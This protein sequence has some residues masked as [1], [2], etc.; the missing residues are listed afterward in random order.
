M[1]S[2]S[3]WAFVGTSWTPGQA[4]RGTR[5][6]RI[7]KRDGVPA[8]NRVPR[9]ENSPREDQTTRG[10]EGQGGKERRAHKGNMT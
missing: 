2:V 6:R 1:V 3:W 7:K 9:D 8:G 5:Y 10:R 4:N